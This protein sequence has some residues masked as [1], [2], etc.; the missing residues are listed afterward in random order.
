MKIVSHNSRMYFAGWLLAALLLLVA[1]VLKLSQLSLEPMIGSSAAVNVLR[2][3][4][5]QFDEIMSAR[6]MDS[7]VRL[8]QTILPARLPKDAPQPP[9]PAVVGTPAEETLPGEPPRFPQLSG[10]LKVA[11]N[12]GQWHYS[13]VMDGSVYSLKDHIRE[14]LIEEISSRG[15]VLSRGKQRWLIPAP[16]VYYSLDQGP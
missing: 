16:E 3:K 12:K 6:R 8:D 13:A 7:E 10:I 9:P 14:F 11:T 1:N 2:L 5:H 15:I 4:L